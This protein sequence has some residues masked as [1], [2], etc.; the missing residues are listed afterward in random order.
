[1]KRIITAIALVIASLATT[2]GFAPTAEAQGY[3]VGWADYKGCNSL[4]T[5]YH[6]RFTE[7]AMYLNGQPDHKRFY[8]DVMTQGGAMLH[9][10]AFHASALWETF[11]AG[12]VYM[13]SNG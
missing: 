4:Q 3:Y 9:Q 8:I 13:N 12:V 1:M 7:H 5:G 11:P 6:Y 10:N 2:V